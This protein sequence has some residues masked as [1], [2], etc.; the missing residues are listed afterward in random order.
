MSKLFRRWRVFHWRRMATTGMVKSMVAY[1]IA[2]RR[3][4]KERNKKSTLERK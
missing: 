3:E 4:R 1:N 2:K